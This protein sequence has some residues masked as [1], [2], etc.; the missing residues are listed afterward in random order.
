MNAKYPTDVDATIL[1]GFTEKWINVVPGFVATALLL[2]APDKPV[3]YLQATNEQG[4]AFLLFYSPH[5]D[6]AFIHQDYLNRGTITV[7][8]GVSGAI[9]I[10]TT[11]QYTKPVFVINGEQDT[12]F[13]GTTGL[14]LTGAGNCGNEPDSIMAETKSLY[15]ASS[16]YSYYILPNSGHCWEHG[17]YAQQGFNA[18]H[19]WMAQ[20]G[21]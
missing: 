18:S 7:G 20:H 8:E 10:V 21:F 17:Y 14:E 11:T 4:V 3:G 13:C 2:P 15:P 19:A 12:V 6:P 1:T 16:S 9:G 5:Y